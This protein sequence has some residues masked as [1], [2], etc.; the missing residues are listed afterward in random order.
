MFAWQDV[1]GPIH[2][3]VTDRQGG[4]SASPFS[5]LNLG[6]H[7]GDDPTSVR[8]NRELVAERLGV[9]AE[10]IAFMRQVHGSRVVHLSAADLRDEDPD[11][12][13]PQADALVTREPEVA[14]VVMVADCIPVLLH[15]PGADVIAV[16]HVGR[17]GL[18]A[19]LL[20]NVVAAMRELGAGPIEAVLG[21]SICGACYEVPDAL[22]REV[23]AVAPEAFTT[24]S[25]GSPGLDLPAGAL[26]Q[27]AR[28]GVHAE[29]LEACTR[30]RADLF[31]YRRDGL[32]GRFGG[33]IVRHTT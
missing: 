11:R 17:P 30:E 7:V 14:L 20:D 2:R 33:A 12:C 5:S 1:A 25:Q 19:R 13:Y 23:A 4:T 3:V 32:T 31:S 9:A 6:D 22:R 18:A 26:A 24:T 15:T 10:R 21:P 16:A 28:L 27:L 29:R 8:A